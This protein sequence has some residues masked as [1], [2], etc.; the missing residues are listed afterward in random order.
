MKLYERFRKVMNGDKNIRTLF[1]RNFGL[2]SETLRCW[3][4]EER[5]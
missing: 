3:Q 4:R 5:F 2:M 1:M